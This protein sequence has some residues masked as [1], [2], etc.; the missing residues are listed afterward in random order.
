MNVFSQRLKQAMQQANMT[1]KR[2]VD[3]TGLGKS[4]IS[5][6]LSGK[7]EPTN[8]NMAIIAEKLGVPLDWLNG[9]Y[10]EPKSASN[11]K[12]ITVE[13]AA[14]VM[15]VGKQMLRQGL[16]NGNFPFGTAVKMPSGKYRYYISPEKFKQF[17][18]CEV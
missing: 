13:T 4:S 18:G 16:K 11:M 8:K 2:L 5:Q 3:E 10:K 17:T 7:N 12:N 15:G 1:Q 14:K 9:G 6:Y